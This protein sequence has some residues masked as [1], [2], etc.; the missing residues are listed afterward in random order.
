MLW[1]V[2]CVYPV[3][4]TDPDHVSLLA[5]QKSYPAVLEETEIFEPGKV[6]AS[7]VSQD[8][9]PPALVS[10]DELA[11]WIP[12]ATPDG[13]LYYF[14]V[15]TGQ[16]ATEMPLVD[17]DT[18]AGSI[19]QI[20]SSSQQEQP[21]KRKRGK[22]RAR[23][24]PTAV[25]VLDDWF[26]QNRTN[27]YPGPDAK[28]ALAVVTGLTI[29]QVDTWFANARQ[30]HKDPTTA[31]D[32]LEQWLSSSSEDEAADIEDIRKAVADADLPASSSGLSSRRRSSV[33]VSR[34]SSM[35]SWGSAFDSCPQAR[36]Q[37]P[38]KRGRKTYGRY[39]ASN[40][41]SASSAASSCSAFAA[42]PIPL[43]ASWKAKQTP[44][45][46]PNTTLPP[47]LNPESSSEADGNYE[48]AIADCYDI[49]H[50]EHEMKEMIE[51]PHSKPLFRSVGLAPDRTPRRQQYWEDAEGKD[52]KSPPQSVAV[53]TEGVLTPKDLHVKS[54]IAIT[55]A[56]DIAPHSS[57]R[58]SRR[59]MLN[60]ELTESLRKQ[61]LWERQTKMSYTS[62][63]QPVEP[64]KGP[65]GSPLPSS[66]PSKLQYQCTFCHVRLSPGAW[67]RHEE[68]Q[69]LPQKQYVCMPDN[70]PYVHDTCVFCKRHQSGITNVR[71]HNYRCTHR[72]ADC[73]KRNFELRT[74]TR[75]DKL[76]QHIRNFHGC[77]IDKT[78]LEKWS[79]EP[80]GNPLSWDCGF[81]NEVEMTWDERAKHIANHFREGK[82]MSM[83]RA[84]SAH[85]S[86]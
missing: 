29:K 12:Q 20:L 44:A 30:R 79:H 41:G 4:G 76:E 43:L 32:P 1:H 21:R 57:P 38:R 54:S 15:L 37:G 24:P 61:L 46:P 69:H 78:V 58:T 42:T 82:D 9:G 59:D 14:N 34:A 63:T 23:L 73:C 5:Q 28:A 26:V 74:F 25:A 50:C 2:D 75:K 70:T 11:F 68:S 40:N 31:P 35:S 67:K 22:K 3:P 83:W 66:V 52:R 48:S 13:R 18:N 19:A 47:T 7:E 36:M 45:K 60:T 64:T 65:H 80:V 81:C 71:M 56:D 17:P 16:S 51:V 84:A 8:A 86:K 27:P 72:V 6:I 10:S 53:R 62:A 49:E 33:A 85:Y 77:S 55:D 39:A